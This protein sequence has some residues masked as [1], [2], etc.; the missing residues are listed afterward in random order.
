MDRFLTRTIERVSSL[1]R[2]QLIR[3]QLTAALLITAS[4]CI[5]RAGALA[6]SDRGLLATRQS[7]TAAAATAEEAALHGSDTEKAQNALLAASLR[8]RLLDG[9]FQVGDRVVVTIVTDVARKDTAVVRSDRT[10]E[11]QGMIVVPVAGVLRSEVRDRVS[12]EVLKYIKAQQIEVVPLMR[13]AVLGAVARPG[14]F[15]FAS[16]IPISEAIMGAGGPTV[17][18]D[19]TRSVVRRGTQEFRSSRQTSQAI[20]GG[21]TL[22]QFG[23][24]AGDELVIGQ[25]RNLGPNVFFGVTGALASV[26]TLFLAIHGRR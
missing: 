17:T 4:I 18:A 1:S 19:V 25:K 15:A 6:Q 14:Y 20:A 2:S 24:A 21:I 8:K 16:D 13:V 22:D 9:D 7:L 23:I 12:S 3:S 5:P 26:L 11:L 10:M